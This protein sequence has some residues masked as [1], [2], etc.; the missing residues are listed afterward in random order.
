MYG[1]RSLSSP[2]FH[3]IRGQMDRLPDAVVTAAAAGVRHRGVDI[4][5]GRIRTSLQQGERAHNHPG[6]AIAALW[7]IEFLPG[8][9]DRMVAIR[10]DP[11]DSGDSLA[12]SRGRKHA[13][14]SNRLTIDMHRARAA[15]PDAAAELGPG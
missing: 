10:R 15:L 12:D 4:G 9:L 3:Q 6:L 13:A 14:G 1:A 11:F 7:R 5:V 2:R 8:D